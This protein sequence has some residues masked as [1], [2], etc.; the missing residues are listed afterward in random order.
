VNKRH[1]IAMF[2]V[3]V[4][5]AGCGKQLSPVGA[6]REHHEDADGRRIDDSIIAY[7][8]FLADGTARFAVMESNAGFSGCSSGTWEQVSDRTGRVALVHPVNS[9]QL[10]PESTYEFEV[11]G[12]TIGNRLLVSA[13]PH[14]ARRD[15]MGPGGNPFDPSSLLEATSWELEQ[16]HRACSDIAQ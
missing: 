1:T 5:Q 7:F 15:W 8:E 13:G 6:W 11:R 4:I 9:D 16:F 10:I 14:R 2:L 3:A 12:Y